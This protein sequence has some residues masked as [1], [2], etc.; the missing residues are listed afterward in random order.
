MAAVSASLSSTLSNASAATA[1]TGVTITATPSVEASSTTIIVP[2]PSPPP[3]LQS[4][5]TKPHPPPS[6][7]SSSSPSDQLVLIA[8]AGGGGGAVLLAVVGYLI[9]RHQRAQSR[10]K[11]HGTS[12]A[13]PHMDYSRKDTRVGLPTPPFRTSRSAANRRFLPGHAHT[14]IRHYSTH[15]TSTAEQIDGFPPLSLRQAAAHLWH[16]TML[17]TVPKPPPASCSHRQS[18]CTYLCTTKATAS[19][20]YL[21]ECCAQDATGAP[22]QI[23]QAGCA[24]AGR[25]VRHMSHQMRQCTTK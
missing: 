12:G 20:P 6:T 22:D 17:R 23:T 3:R 19:P 24:R 15:H 5:T 1:F 16:T 18:S 9:L 14:N 4:I 25:D 10:S 13:A 21:T 7:S 11:G 2:A 8:A